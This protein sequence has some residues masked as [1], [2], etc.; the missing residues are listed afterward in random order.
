MQFGIRSGADARRIAEADIFS[1]G[2]EIEIELLVVSGGIAL[3]ID[4]AAAR[5]GRELLNI[6]SVAG[7][8]Q[9]AVHLAEAARQSG[10]IPRPVLNLDGA[11][12]QVD[13]E[14]LRRR[15]CER[16]SIRK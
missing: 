13:R 4:R 3:E 15:S 10:I 16:T 8:G 7:E 11:L 1:D 5:A 9:G 14:S 6:N 12:R 2:R